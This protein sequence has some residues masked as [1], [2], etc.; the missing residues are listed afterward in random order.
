MVASG[1]LTENRP[2]GTRVM[3]EGR[4][5]TQT[6]RAAT[7]RGRRAAK[8]S[9]VIDRVRL[10]GGDARGRRA[11]CVVVRRKVAKR[12]TAL[13]ANVVALRLANPI[14]LAGAILRHLY[15]VRAPVL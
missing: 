11:G 8:H 7:A 9:R 5:T 13:R 10:E 1:G 2:R 15:A 4:D 3:N 14:L 12:T 6:G